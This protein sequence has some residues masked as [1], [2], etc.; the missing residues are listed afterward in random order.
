LPG[1]IADSA[2]LGK[3]YSSLQ[4]MRSKPDAVGVLKKSDEK[5]CLFVGLLVQSGC[6][7]SRFNA[8]RRLHPMTLFAILV[9]NPA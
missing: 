4:Q 5:I 8:W 2:G 3:V 6:R 1:D 9:G 7:C